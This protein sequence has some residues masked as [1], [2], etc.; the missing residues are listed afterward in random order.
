MHRR[1]DRRLVVPSPD[2]LDE[3]LAGDHDP[4]AAVL[5]EPTHRAKPRFQPAVV[6][7]DAVVGIPIGPV[8][9]CRRCGFSMPQV[10]QT[11]QRRAYADGG[12]T[13]MVSW[14]TSA[15]MLSSG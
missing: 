5:L 10:D 2:V 12:A 8:P 13:V 1:L 4:G 6:G 7:L 14:S 3:G 9:G 15:R 11:Q